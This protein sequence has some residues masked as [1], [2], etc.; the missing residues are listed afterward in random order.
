MKPKNRS[1][2]TICSRK[3]RVLKHFRKLAR[4][5]ARALVTQY[6]LTDQD[7]FNIFFEELDKAIIQR[8]IQK[9]NNYGNNGS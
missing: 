7:R 2:S 9:G 3:E 4:T 8:R 6:L 1:Q 5:R